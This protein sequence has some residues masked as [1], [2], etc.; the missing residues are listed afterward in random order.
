MG[1][2]KGRCRLKHKHS[3]GSLR[4]CEHKIVGGKIV[5]IRSTKKQE[6]AEVKI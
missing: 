5:E 1:R 2:G 6:M 3:I 4:K